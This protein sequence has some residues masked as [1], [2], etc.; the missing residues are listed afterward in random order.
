MLKE[1]VQIQKPASEIILFYKK[2]NSFNVTDF[3]TYLEDNV[4]L[5]NKTIEIDGLEYKDE[6]TYD[7]IDSYF[8]TIKEYSNKKQIN[9]LSNKLKNE[10][11][12]VVRK[13]IAKKIEA[14]IKE[15]K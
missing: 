7:E 6:Y 1:I 13:E 11:N 10:T 2:Y 3:I 8:N 14:I 5:I 12:E 4:E 9:E 15:S